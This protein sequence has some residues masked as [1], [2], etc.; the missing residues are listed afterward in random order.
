MAT[1]QGIR[2]GRMFFD[3]ECRRLPPL[4]RVTRRAL[5]LIRALGKLAFVWIRL[6]AVDALGENQRLLEVA[7][8][9]ALGA[10]H[11]RVL[12]L[13]RELRFR[14][15]KMLV[16]CMQR[17][18]LPAAR[19]VTGL[20]TLREAAV[21]RILMAVGTLVEWNANVLRLAVCPIRVAL[22][23]LHLQVEPSQR[24]ACLGVIELAHVDRLPIHEVVARST[25][26]AQPSLVLILVAS[27]AGGGK[28]EI[29]STRVFDLDRR[30]FLGRNVRGIVALGAF[31]PS[32][33]ALENV[34]SL[35]VIK[36]FDIP[37]DQR[38]IF[39]VVLGMAAGTLLA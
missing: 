19:V 30:A 22:G 10:I 33:L 37:L 18:L 13:Q 17:N 27:H 20:A 3:R 25:I 39:T 34:P 26:L 23:A 15:I 9:M 16:H 7:V 1:L 2:R 28:A 38:K 29:R 32:M 24:V 35:L 11:T 5:S 14:V 36:G 8:R 6:V 31:Q 4:H 21:M 12:P